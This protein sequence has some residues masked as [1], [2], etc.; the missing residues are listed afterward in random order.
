MI[1]AALAGMALPAAASGVPAMASTVVDPGDGKPSPRCH[2]KPT[3]KSD[4]PTS[5]PTQTK[6]PTP[7]PTRPD[8][9]QPTDG[10]GGGSG[11]GAAGPGATGPGGQPLQPGRAGQPA[12]GGGGGGPAGVPAP[13]PAPAGNAISNDSGSGP[14]GGGGTRAQPART[15]S[16]FSA[17]RPIWPFLLGGT[18][19]IGLIT[20][21]LLVTLRD[22]PSRPGRGEPVGPV[23]SSDRAVASPR[24][25]IRMEWIEPSD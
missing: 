10:G 6:D 24:G 15:S 7:T 17:A 16:L 9:T 18:L 12:N 21:G 3:C 14:D 2:P 25:P 5:S 23:P 8:A 13:I 11:P 4:E 20:T 22:K 19:L 1:V